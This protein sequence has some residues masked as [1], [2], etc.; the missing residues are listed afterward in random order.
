MHWIKAKMFLLSITFCWIVLFLVM[1]PIQLPVTIAAIWVKGLK[2]YRYGLWIGQDQLINAMHNGNP[3]VTVSSKIGYMAMKGSNT[4][5]VME[6]VVNFLFYISVG[7][8]DHCKA[9]IE[10]DEEHF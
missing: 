8:K 6:K 5:L 3:D 1:S 9:S 7:Q 2:R 10:Y 4:A